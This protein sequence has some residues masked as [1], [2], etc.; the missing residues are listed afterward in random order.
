MK[1]SNLKTSYGELVIKSHSIDFAASQNST[2]IR[3]KSASV[4]EIYDRLWISYGD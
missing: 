4:E 1:Y 3:K 2:Q